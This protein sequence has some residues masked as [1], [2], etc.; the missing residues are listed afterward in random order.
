MGHYLA[1]MMCDRCRRYPCVCLVEKREDATANH[2]IVAEDFSVQRAGEYQRLSAKTHS[3]V[4]F[5]KRMSKQHFQNR[6]DAEEEARRQCQD[7]LEAARAKVS[8]LE[9]ILSLERPWKSTE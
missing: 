8:E 4:G 9:Q 2:W 3:A 1:E 5:Y 7:A 6:E